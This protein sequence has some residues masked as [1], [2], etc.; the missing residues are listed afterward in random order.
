MSA[1]VNID[2]TERKEAEEALR[3]AK[4]RLDLAVRGSNIG[5]WENDMPGGDFQAGVLHCTNIFEQ[6]GYPPP[7]GGLDYAAVVAPM[8]PDDR[9]RVEQAVAAY[10]A[11]RTP[12]FAVEFRA[13]HRDGSCR[14]LL[15]RGI[16]VR[17]GGGRPV[18]FAGT[19]I[20]ITDLKRIE[21]ELR[22]AKEAAEAASRSQAADRHVSRG[23]ADPPGNG[24]VSGR[25][26]RVCA[27][28]RAGCGRG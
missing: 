4:A 15:S 6:L 23:I 22:Q 17:D 1:I 14:C 12:E 19:R 9:P 24:R 8:H 18:R 28:I 27:R 25:R 3:R 11:G 2:I 7:D 21:D 26:G 5:I 10:L 20:D 16:A 13:R